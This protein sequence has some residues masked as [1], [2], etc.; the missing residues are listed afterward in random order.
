MAVQEQMKVAFGSSRRKSKESD[1]GKNA[2]RK[3]IDN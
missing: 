3:K 1:K 2:K